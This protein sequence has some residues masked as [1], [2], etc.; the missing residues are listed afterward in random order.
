MLNKLKKFTAGILALSMLSV[1]GGMFQA[2]AESGIDFS[3]LGAVGEFTAE[4]TQ[5]IAEQIYDGIAKHE[6]YISVGNGKDVYISATLDEMESVMAIY[7]GVISAWDVGILTSRFM[8]TYQVPKRGKMKLTP[9]YLETENYEEVYQGLMQ[10]IDEI[11]SGMEKDWS[12]VEKALYLHDYI[13][14]HYDYDYAEY[15]YGSTEEE[16]QHTAYGMLKNG[17]AVCEGYAWLYG[18]LLHKV[19]IDSMLV[20]STNIRHGWNLVYLEGKWYHVDVTWDDYLNGHPGLGEHA[21]FFKDSDYFYENSHDSEDWVLSTET[22]VE[23]LPVSDFYQNGFWNDCNSS[24]QPYQGKW[25]VI[26]CDPDEDDTTAWFDVCTF[27]AE[28]G[29]SETEHLLSLDAKWARWHVFGDEDWCYGGTFISPVVYGDKIYYTTPTSVFCLENQQ[30]QWLFDLDEEQKQE[31]YIYGMTEKNHQLC[32]YISTEPEGEPKEYYYSLEEENTPT[33]TETEENAT[34][35]ETVSP[36][37][38]EEEPTTEEM[39]PPIEPE[40][41]TTEEFIPPTEPEEPTTE[42]FIPPTEPD[43]LKGDF[44]GDYLWSVED[45]IFLQNYL[46]GKE[47]APELALAD[48]NN[49]GIIN[50]FDLTLLKKLILA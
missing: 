24:I 40:E 36:T 21:F 33:E 6:S 12:P 13:I 45:A 28:T 27:D 22:P 32:Y 19:G 49:D 29:E 43:I 17:K 1:Y 4:E 26:H 50:I 3:Y 25:L 37:E 35:E 39:I 8:I 5:Q 18:I 20:E 9:V 15:S 11:I 10:E 16:L 7:R 30:V 2:K 23:E 14:K 38:P 47:N 41:P 34:T 31:G 46:L 48:M 44:N 42:E